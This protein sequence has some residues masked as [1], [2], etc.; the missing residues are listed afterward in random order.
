MPSIPQ[1]AIY[2][3]TANFLKF[4][5]AN[6]YPEAILRDDLKKLYEDWKKDLVQRDVPFRLIIRN[7]RISQ[8]IHEFGDYYCMFL[9]DG[10]PDL[11]KLHKLYTS[12]AWKELLDRR[13]KLA[14]NNLY[15]CMVHIQKKSLRIA[16][17]GIKDAKVVCMSVHPSP[18]RLSRFPFSYDFSTV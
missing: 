17:M 4:L 9:G 18:V 2:N 8:R 7:L 10:T 13:K 14:E 16:K 11:D 5:D 15:Y 1:T 3:A 6:E 12:D